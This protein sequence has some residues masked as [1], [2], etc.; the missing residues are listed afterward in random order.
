[1][2]VCWKTSRGEVHE[3]DLQF[4]RQAVVEKEDHGHRPG[5]RR[6]RDVQ[7]PSALGKRDGMSAV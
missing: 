1:M 7:K 4:W 5:H 2:R 3:K 6:Q